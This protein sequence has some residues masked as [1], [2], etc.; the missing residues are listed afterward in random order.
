MLFITFIVRRDVDIYNR[1]QLFFQII[2][3]DLLDRSNQWQRITCEKM[4][5]LQIA[6]KGARDREVPLIF[7]TATKS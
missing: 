5:L 3:G 7:L 6:W 1:L 2:S 4:S